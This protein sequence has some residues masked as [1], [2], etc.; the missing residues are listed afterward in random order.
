M[1]FVNERKIEVTI[2][3]EAHQVLLSKWASVGRTFDNIEACL[4]KFLESSIDD[5]ARSEA[6]LALEEIRALH[7]P[8]EC[9]HQSAQS[10]LWRDACGKILKKIGTFE[11]SCRLHKDHTQGCKG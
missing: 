10:A 7:R 6:E 3:L 1:S 8:L 2:H 11:V 9:L 5:D 4:E